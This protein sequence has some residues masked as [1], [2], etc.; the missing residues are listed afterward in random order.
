LKRG[1]VTHHRVKTGIDHRC[2]LWPETVEALRAAIAARRTPKVPEDA[3]LVFVTSRGGSWSKDHA[4]NPI[5]RETVKVLRTLGLHKKGRSF[6]SLRHAFETIAGG[7]RD[8]PAVDHIMGHAPAQNDMAAV[9][10]EGIEDARLVAV[11]EHVRAWLFGDQES[12]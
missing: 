10:R 11:A 7:L 4:D 5:S 12:K 1:W 6:Y 9:Y 3:A 2:P 8:Q